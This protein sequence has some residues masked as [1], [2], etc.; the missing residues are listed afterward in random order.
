M[1]SKILLSNIRAGLQRSAPIFCLVGTLGAA[2]WLHFGAESRGHIVAFAQSTPEAIAPTEIAKVLRIDVQVG[3]TVEAGQIVANLDTAAIDGEIALAE[4]ERA[5][6]EAAMRAEQKLLARR[7]DVD[8]ESLEREVARQRE[9]QLRAAAQAKALDVEVLRVKHLVDDH[10][11]VYD[12]YARLDLQRASVAAVAT[13]KPKTLQLLAKQLKAAKDRRKEL[14]EGDTDLAEKFAADLRVAQRNIERLKQRRSSYVLRATQRGRVAAIDKRPGEVAAPGDA[15]VRLVSTGSRVVACVPERVAL[16]IREG[17]PAK[18]WIRGQQSAILHG[19]TV[20]L[21]PLVT[22]LPARCWVTPKVPMWGREV[23]VELEGPMDVLAGQAFD[24]V[25]EPAKVPPSPALPKSAAANQAAATPQAMKMP[26]A[27]AQRTRFE[28]SG[29]L[30]QPGEGRYLVISDDTGRD[31]DEGAPWIFAM[32]KDGDLQSEPLTIHGIDELSDV[33]AIAAGDAGE[34]YLL[35]SQSYS[36]KGK[37]KAARTALLRLRKQGSGYRVDGE[38]HL[39]E[40]LDADSARATALGLPDG[41]RN[42]DIEGLA[43][44][45]GALY[46]GLKAPLD[47]QGKALIWKIE[48][49]AALFE[50]KPLASVGA[51]AW[52]RVRVDVEVDGKNTPGG[53]SDL[54]FLPDG[55]LAITSTPATA[56]GDGGALWRV[57]APESGSLNPSL[58]KR[59][60]GLKPEGI[61]QSFAPDKLMVVFDTGGGAPL[62]EEI[63]WMH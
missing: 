22:E 29:I 42:L 37:R 20:V 23:T 47:A 30:A 21:G 35:S 28:P 55:K 63:P 51:S 46:L 43:T 57:D 14:N 12:D 44:R 53:I 16:G 48:S 58:V 5:R 26:P 27:L 32:S 59:F 54:L 61:S 39:A 8:L 4:A 50:G 52:A 9:D 62:F 1:K 15:V 36:K 31:G 19:K 40:L 13:E 34:I 38:A 10:Q 41:T 11:A 45:D 7:L 3:D 17:D 60:P 2:A 6:L 56:D 33:E 24:V 18:L 25:F 49:P